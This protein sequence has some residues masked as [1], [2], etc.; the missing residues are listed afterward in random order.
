MS[1]KTKINGP[2]KEIK[3]SIGTTVLYSCLSHK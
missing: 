1:G 2:L 3:A